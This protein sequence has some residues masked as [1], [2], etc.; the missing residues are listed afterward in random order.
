MGDALRAAR[1]WKLTAESSGWA[2]DSTLKAYSNC[3]NYVPKR[4]NFFLNFER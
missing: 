2:M 4:E 3:H 1:S